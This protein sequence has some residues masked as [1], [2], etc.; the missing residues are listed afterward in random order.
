MHW[1]F[2]LSSIICSLLVYFIY[3]FWPPV[4]YFLII[5]VPYIIIGIHDVL[6]FKHTVLRNY[7]VVGHLRYMLEF[8]RPEIQQYF[9][10]SDK[11]G[12]PFPREIRSLVYQKSK[13]VRETIAF[14]T[15]NN[16]TDV[17]YQFSYP[18]LSPKEVSNEKARI[19]IEGKD[20]T[21]PYDASRLNVSGMSFGA[22][23][24]NA[25]RAL[26]KGA[27]IGSFAHNTGEGGISPY[28]LEH[29]G[30]LI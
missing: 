25:I 16:I 2:Y 8:I 12:T 14:G 9:I 11:D 6:S 24:P 17:G 23:S 21:K 26:N 20:C 22:L 10:E 15:K 30:D 19:I 5:L 29:G 18:S 13:G 28:H 7:P 3:Q 4:I 1:F 27:S